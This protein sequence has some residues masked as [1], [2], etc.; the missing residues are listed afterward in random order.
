MF[1]PVKSTIF[2]DLNMS[3]TNIRDEVYNIV[4]FGISGTICVI[5]IILCVANI[6]RSG[7]IKSDSNGLTLIRSMLLG[8]SIFQLF[9]QIGYF[10]GNGMSLW[11]DLL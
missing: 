2:V 5:I 10:I 6:H 7:Y 4:I 1:S 9:N 11:N 3:N 8:C